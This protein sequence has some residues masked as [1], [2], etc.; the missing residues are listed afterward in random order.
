MYGNKA[1]SNSTFDTYKF[2]KSTETGMITDRLIQEANSQKK[3]LTAK[4]VKSHKA[5]GN[6]VSVI[7]NMKVVL[8]VWKE[9]AELWNLFE[10]APNGKKR[11]TEEILDRIDQQRSE[12]LEFYNQGFN[13][14]GDSGYYKAVAHLYELLNESNSPVLF[15]SEVPRQKKEQRKTQH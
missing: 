9:Y 5:R 1:L 14:D 11:S 12:E 10:Y 7:M 4:Y 8:A 13:D 6:P 2:I 3:P 15:R